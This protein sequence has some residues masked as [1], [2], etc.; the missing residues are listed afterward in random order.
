MGDQLAPSTKSGEGGEIEQNTVH[1][2][3]QTAGQ[4]GSHYSRPAADNTL[5]TTERAYCTDG[6]RKKY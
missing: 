3:Y 5:S 4:A 2:S 1:F 6:R